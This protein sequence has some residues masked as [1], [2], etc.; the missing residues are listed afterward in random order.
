MTPLI[1]QMS[2]SAPR[3]GLDPDVLGAHPRQAL[4]PRRPRRD[5]VEEDLLGPY[6]V[7]SKRNY[8]RK[9]L[10]EIHTET[11][12]GEGC[13]AQIHVMRRT[14]GGNESC[15]KTTAAARRLLL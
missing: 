5:L 1:R 6:K 12:V 8:M 9:V 11:F 15:L 2:C 7:T 3:G 14:H 13:D 4:H 10:V